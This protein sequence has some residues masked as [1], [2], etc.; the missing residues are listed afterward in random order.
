MWNEHCTYYWLFNKI[1][2]VRRMR[3]ENMQ[4]IILN[5]G[6]EMPLLGYGTFQIFERELCRQCIYEAI[7]AGYRLF[8]TAA[9]YGNEEAF[10]EA[11][12]HA[13][14][15]GIVER[16]ELFITTKVWV[17]DSGYEATRKAYELSLKR[18][19]LDYLD[20]YL[21]HQPLGDYY[22]SLRAMEEKNIGKPL[23]R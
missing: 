16:K 13:L 14:K 8:D 5:N 9:S 22:G 3:N 15:D 4:N 10:G 7:K 2:S 12:A 21:I 20:L 18:L 1:L 19:E 6:I 23:H 17:Q 11:I